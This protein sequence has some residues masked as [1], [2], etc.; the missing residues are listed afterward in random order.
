MNNNELQ[1]QQLSQK[2]EREVRYLIGDLQMQILLLRS[3]LEQAQPPQ[4]QPGEPK[5]KPQP[6][7]EPQPEPPPK[8]VEEP[9]PEQPQA[10]GRYQERIAR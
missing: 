7:P 10:N 3:V 4:P 2:I 8:P 9:Q 5:P 1:S 6:R